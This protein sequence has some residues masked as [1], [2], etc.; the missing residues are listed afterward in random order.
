[1]IVAAILVLASCV[2]LATLGWARAWVLVNR[3][4]LEQAERVDV[5]KLRDEVRALRSE[6]ETEQKRAVLGRR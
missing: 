4:R 6:I 1:V 5:G 3:D 2:A